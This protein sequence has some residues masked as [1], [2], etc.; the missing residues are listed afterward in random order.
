VSIQSTNSEAF[1]DLPITSTNPAKP[2]QTAPPEKV[3]RH[4]Q[5]EGN[6]PKNLAA[7]L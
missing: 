4:A 6:Q 7:A 1:T 5:D 2:R 3:F